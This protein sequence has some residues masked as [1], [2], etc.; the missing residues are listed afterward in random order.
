MLI[1]MFLEGLTLSFPPDPSLRST[2]Y[3]GQYWVKSEVNGVLEL[4][5]WVTLV[6]PIRLIR[7]G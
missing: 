2:P 4:E 5:N 7:L 3:P 6:V 1:A